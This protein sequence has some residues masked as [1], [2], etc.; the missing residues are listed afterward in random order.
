MENKDLT[1]TLATWVSRFGRH[2][3]LAVPTPEI[4]LEALP[5]N[6][7]GHFRPAGIAGRDR[8][9][10]VLNSRQLDRPLWKVLETLLHQ[11]LHQWQH[12]HGKPGRRN[13]HNRAFRDRAKGCGLVVEADGS[14]R[15]RARS[16]LRVLLRKYQLTTSAKARP[17][18]TS[19][20]RPTKTKLRKWTCGCTNVRAAVADFQAQCLKCGRVFKLD[21]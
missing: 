5:S 19:V 4:R 15:S 17:L 10:I 18:S 14:T 13:Y 1:R 7:P 16:P 3:R 20:D 21:L 2:F 8:D 9:E 11:Q 6:Q 12:H